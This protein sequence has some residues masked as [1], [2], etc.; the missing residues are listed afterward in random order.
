MNDRTLA[1]N[2][3]G[4]LIDAHRAALTAPEGAE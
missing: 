1:F 4:L 3:W 2:I